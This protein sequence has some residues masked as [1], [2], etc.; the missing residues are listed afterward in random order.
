MKIALVR[1]RYTAYGGAERFVARAIQALQGRGA[2]ITL[3]TRQWA[4]AKHGEGHDQLLV[5]DPFYLGSLW[6]DWGFS[7]SV[8]DALS[9]RHFDLVQSHERIACCDIY[10]AGDGV[11]REW[12]EQRR[13][14]LGF[15]GRAGIWLNPCHH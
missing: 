10:R 7:R 2:E 8:C 4:E 13:R 12:L 14:V 11:H 15:F 5:C 1:Q 6:R 3:V 9:Q